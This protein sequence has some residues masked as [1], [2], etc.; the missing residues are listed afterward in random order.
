VPDRNPHKPSNE[1]YVQNPFEASHWFLAVF[2]LTMDIVGL[3][4]VGW[5]FFC[6]C[7]SLLYCYVTSYIAEIVESNFLF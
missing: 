3:V 1:Q 4:V 6:F 5:L 2:L 7:N